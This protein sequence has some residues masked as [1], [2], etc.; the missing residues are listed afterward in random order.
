MRD[1]CYQN[2]LQLPKSYLFQANDV[3]NLPF[4]PD[5]APFPTMKV[6]FILGLADLV[7]VAYY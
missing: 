1:S 7:Y 5:S 3:F 4:K 6:L 2:F